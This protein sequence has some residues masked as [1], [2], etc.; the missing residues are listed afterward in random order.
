MLK[1][2]FD[3][4]QLSKVLTSADV[5]GWD[6]L[7]KY[8]DVET[9]ISHIVQYWIKS[10]L[11]LLPLNVKSVKSK[12][13]FTPAVMEDVFAIRLVDRF[14]RR[15]YKVRQSDRNRIIRQLKTILED[16]GN[17]HILRLDIKDCYETI[18]LEKLISKLESDTILAPECMGLLHVIL[19]DLK[20][21]HGVNGL[22]R[23][24]SIS[25]TLAEIYLEGLDKKIASHP[26]IIYSSRYVDDIIIVVSSGRESGVKKDI[27]VFLNDLGLSLNINNKFYSG[28]SSSAEFDYLGYAIKVDAKKNK[29]NEVCLK[30]SDSKL[31]KIKT[32]IVLSFC[33]HKRQR[34]ISL[35]KR[36]IEYLCM[37]KIVRKGKNGDLLAG[38]SHNYQ[39]VTDSFDCLKSLDGFLCQ[40]VSSPRFGLR[41]QEQVLIKKLSIYGAAKNRKVGKFSKS[42]TVR[43]MRVWKNA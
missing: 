39:Y 11:K 20:V 1:Q 34:D 18:S 6:L 24:L 23:G 27:E 15:I 12:L 29:P 28:S 41:Q 32:R 10:N 26:D 37:L 14:I 4:G 5:W 42:Q 33:D 8:G 40:Q 38:L 35:L 22:P 9:A 13:I 36:R 43:I 25:P 21:N 3:I 7:S 31:D 17:Y 2:V 16:S 30:V 19:N